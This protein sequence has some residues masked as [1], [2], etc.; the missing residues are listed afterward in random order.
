MARASKSRITGPYLIAFLAL[1][2][3]LGGSALAIS[4]ASV[5]SKHIKDNT[6][7]GRDV[8]DNSLTG[9]DVDESTLAL[10]KDEV[11][12]APAPAA[13][14]AVDLPAGDPIPAPPTSATPS[15]PAGGALAGSYPNPLLAHGSVASAQVAADTL[16]SQDLAPNSVESSEIES[17]SVT[18][19]EIATGSVLSA[20]IADGSLDGDDVG[21]DSGT[22]SFDAPV[23]LG[24]ECLGRIANLGTSGSLLN[25][26]IVVTPGN[27]W[28]TSLS[29][30]ETNTSTPGAVIVTMC[31]NRQISIDPPPT[32]LHWV[33]FDVN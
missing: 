12:A 27:S 18:S 4:K 31:N 1:F 6:V 22:V 26:A 25:D 11:P 2:V 21:R 33:A 19:S 9:A 10:S 20:E 3:A 23:I 28:P 8:R 24:N 13:P 29:M 15:G 16:G 7:A 14:P 32:D 17:N 30:T 5:K